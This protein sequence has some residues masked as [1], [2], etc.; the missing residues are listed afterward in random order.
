MNAASSAH[1]ILDIMLQHLGYRVTACTAPSAALSMFIDDPWSFSAVMTDMNMPEISGVQ[2]AT[3]VLRVRP[4]V[5]VLLASGFITDELQTEAVRLGVAEV[6]HKPLSIAQ[7]SEALARVLT[8][9]DLP[10]LA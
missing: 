2:L 1:E 3:E 9:P 7:L 6:L 10:D 8:T 4:D 5:P